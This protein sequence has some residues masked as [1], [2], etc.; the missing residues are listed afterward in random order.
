M[1]Q[2]TEQCTKFQ[3]GSTGQKGHN[4]KFSHDSEACVLNSGLEMS[5]KNRLQF[6]TNLEYG[7]WVVSNHYHADL[8][9]IKTKNFFQS[10]CI[11]Q[12]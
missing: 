5:A 8:E 6:L 10:K 2:D 11:K 4:N 12:H 1:A 3:R 9:T 7:I